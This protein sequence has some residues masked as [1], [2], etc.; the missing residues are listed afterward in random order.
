MKLSERRCLDK[1]DVEPAWILACGDPQC[2]EIIADETECGPYVR[3]LEAENEK[4][5][6]EIQPLKRFW[7]L[8]SESLFNGYHFDA[9]DIFKNA[10]EAGLLVYEQY[11]PNGRHK[12]LN[13][14]EV[15]EGDMFYLL[16][17]VADNLD[18]EGQDGD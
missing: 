7:E 9:S 14:P 5:A 3:T 13:V 2:P 10:E 1:H 16:K 6:Q 11:D 15:L 17:S 18:W 12:G 4:L 8:I